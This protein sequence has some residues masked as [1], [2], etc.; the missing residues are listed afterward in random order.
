MYIAWAQVV[1]PGAKDGA[2]P[3]V[4]K[5]LVSVGWN[6]AYDNEEKTVEAYVC[7]E[8]E[9]DFYGDE[10]RLLIVGYVRPQVRRR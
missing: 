7:S 5:A 8:F 10:L 1:K 4:H 6:P 9:N 2:A 3:P